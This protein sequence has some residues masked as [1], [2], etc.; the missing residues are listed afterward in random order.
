MIRSMKS[1]AKANG[2]SLSYFKKKFGH[3]YMLVARLNNYQGRIGLYISR[4]ELAETSIMV[5]RG[6]VV[7]RGYPD[8]TS[9]LSV[10]FEMVTEDLWGVVGIRFF[11]TEKEVSFDA[12]RFEIGVL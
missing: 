8:D 6:A 9:R 12:P 1:F 2:Y 11:E 10:K 3:E 4:D 5:Q 7:M